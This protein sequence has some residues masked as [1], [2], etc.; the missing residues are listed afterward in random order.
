M[1][2]IK[3]NCPSC[4]DIEFTPSDIVINFVYE[5]GGGEYSFTCP[6]CRTRINKITTE[7]NIDL[8]IAAGVML[9]SGVVTKDQ[10]PELLHPSQVVQPVFTEVDYLEFASML[11]CEDEIEWFKELRES[12]E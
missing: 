5:S 8:L 7:K 4:G 3:A 11:D 6:E 1:R 10:Y 12:L 9:E 2:N